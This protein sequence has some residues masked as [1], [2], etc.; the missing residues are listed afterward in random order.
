[1]KG[2][3]PEKSAIRSHRIREFT[4][5]EFGPTAREI[6]AQD[7]TL[8]SIQEIDPSPALPACGEGVTCFDVLT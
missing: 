5:S 3:N 6:L 1:M 2:F 4:F 7:E 8:G